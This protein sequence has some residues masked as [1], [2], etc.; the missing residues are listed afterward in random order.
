[1]INLRFKNIIGILAG[2]FIT[3][4]FIPQVLKVKNTKNI[5]G[6]SFPMYIIFIIGIILWLIYGF[7]IKSNEIIISNFVMLPLASYILYYL[8]LN[9][10]K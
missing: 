3:I 1:M 2:L 10:T 7:L 6:I 8:I 5:D 4:S 9:K